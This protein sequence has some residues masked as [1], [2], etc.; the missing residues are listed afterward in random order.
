MQ[1]IL[2]EA[3]NGSAGYPG[4]HTERE[5]HELLLEDGPHATNIANQRG[6]V[7]IARARDAC[8]AAR[9]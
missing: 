1:R 9:W 2:D 7:K 4:R 5:G 3:P 8:Q 6:R